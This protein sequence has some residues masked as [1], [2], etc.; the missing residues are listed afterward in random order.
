[1][2]VNPGERILYGKYAGFEVELDLPKEGGVDGETEK[3]KHLVMQ[4]GDVVA[5]ITEGE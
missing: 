2:W 3:V 4:M 1:M 5:T